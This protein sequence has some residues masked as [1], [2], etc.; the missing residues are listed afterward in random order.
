[1]Y[2]AF[3]VTSVVALSSLIANVYLIVLGLSELSDDLAG[4]S[5]RHRPSHPSTQ[6]RPQAHFRGDHLTA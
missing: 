4:A 5:L 2:S 6:G 1:M 3:L